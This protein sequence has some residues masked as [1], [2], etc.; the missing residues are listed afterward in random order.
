MSKKCGSKKFCVIKIKRRNIA[1][2]ILDVAEAMLDV[3]EAM[4]DVA[5][6]ITWPKF[7]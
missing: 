3:V 2:N 7:F 1:E 5:E 6:V 4:L